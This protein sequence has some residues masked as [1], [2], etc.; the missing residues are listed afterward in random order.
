MAVGGL[1]QG[2]GSKKSQIWRHV[3]SICMWSERGRGV[4]LA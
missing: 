2:G 1:D 3:L 4:L